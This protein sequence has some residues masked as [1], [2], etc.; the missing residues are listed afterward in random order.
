LKEREYDTDP[1]FLFCALSG[2]DAALLYL[3]AVLGSA[4]SPNLMISTVISNTPLPPTGN[5]L[6]TK[7]SCPAGRVPRRNQSPRD[8][9]T[10]KICRSPPSDFAS[11]QPMDRK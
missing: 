6:K 2:A 11:H 4:F 8:G 3:R 5:H 9:I 7:D 1:C 10:A